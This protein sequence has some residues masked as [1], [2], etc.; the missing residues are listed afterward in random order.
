MLDLLTT[1]WLSK[2]D[3]ARVPCNHAVFTK[4]RLWLKVKW[5]SGVTTDTGWK[6]I[7]SKVT[8]NPVNNIYVLRANFCIKQ[9]FGNTEWGVTGN[10]V[11]VSRELGA[12]EFVFS[13]LQ[14]KNFPGKHQKL[15][16]TLIYLRVKVSFVLAITRRKLGKQGPEGNVIG[17][18]FIPV[19]MIWGWICN[20]TSKNKQTTT[21]TT[22]VK[23]GPLCQQFPHKGTMLYK[24]NSAEF[25][26]QFRCAIFFYWPGWARS[27]PVESNVMNNS[28][29]YIWLLAITTSLQHLQKHVL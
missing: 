8:P 19:L 2:D 11:R 3:V 9:G 7:T 22:N 13:S 15:D 17:C 4:G 28:R 21:P 14:V 25:P 29:G 26:F 27:S 20:S 18:T 23:Y 10:V 6:S 12:E 16:V 5:G 24:Y 1:G